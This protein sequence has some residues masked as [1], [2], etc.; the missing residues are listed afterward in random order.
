MMN[1]EKIKGYAGLVVLLI[2]LM[3]LFYLFF[4]YILIYTLPFFIGW[5]LAI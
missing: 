5:F 3:L 4:K 2:G 1:Y